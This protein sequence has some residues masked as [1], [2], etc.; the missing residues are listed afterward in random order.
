MVGRARR[1]G[2]RG[3]G[4]RRFRRRRGAGRDR[5]GRRPGATLGR[6]I[7][8]RSGPFWVRERSRY[9][10]GVWKGDVD[11]GRCLGF[12]L[13]RCRRLRDRPRPRAA[14]DLGGGLRWSLGRADEGEVAVGVGVPSSAVNFGVPRQG[15]EGVGHLLFGGGIGG[16][17]RAR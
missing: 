13:R 7:L 14:V 9:H 8:G 5:E 12:S 16:H 6:A 10:N 4:L 11:N 15:T 1:P 3:L 2:A 17:P